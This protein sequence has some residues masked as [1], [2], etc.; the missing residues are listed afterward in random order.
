MK[1]RKLSAALIASA[2]LVMPL[3]SYIT[4]SAD[5]TQVVFNT[6]NI[7]GVTEGDAVSPEFTPENDVEV[8]SIL[9]YHWNGGAGSKAGTISV[10][11]GEELV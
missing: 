5:D 8:F 3:S 1:L 9:T 10:Y 4:A 2:V 11:D 7:S 6:Y